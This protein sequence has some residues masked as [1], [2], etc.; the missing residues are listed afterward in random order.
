MS[1]AHSRFRVIDGGSAPQAGA[2][3]KRKSDAVM[4]LCRTCESD[5][6]VATSA[7][8][9]AKLNPMERGGKIEGGSDALVCAHCLG[10]GKV[11][12]LT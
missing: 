4:C 2:R 9:K 8:I 12:R 10:R 1:D 11:T 3:K 7:W 6:G 5:I